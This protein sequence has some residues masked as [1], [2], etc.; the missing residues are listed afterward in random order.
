ME[1]GERLRELRKEKRLT[2]KQ[3][4]EKFKL[5]ESTISGYETGARKPDI[6]LIK[7]FAKF[8]DVTIDYLLGESSDRKG[9]IVGSAFYDYD[10]ITEEEKDYLDL[11]L[12]IFR[13]MKKKQ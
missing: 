4:G 12:E 1:F 6:E 5:A 13:K 7:A 8:F 9:N 10:N 2:S 3:F 11:Q